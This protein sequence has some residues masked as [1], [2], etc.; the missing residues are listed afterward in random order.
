MSAAKRT[1]LI[2]KLQKV[3]KKHF[4]PHLPPADRP[5]LEH[6]LYACCLEDARPDAADQ[7]FALLQ[8]RYFDWNEVR[9]TSQTELA[10]VMGALK[11]P[12]AAANRLKRSLQAV[13]EE[14]YTFALEDIFKKLNLGEA[15]KRVERLEGVSPFVTSYLVQHAFGGHAIPLSQGGIEVLRIIGVISDAEAREKRAPG[16]ERAIPKTK[17]IE[18]ASLLQQLAAELAAAPFGPHIKSLLLEIDSDAKQRL[19]QRSSKSK[20]EAPSKSTGKS[21][22][23]TKSAEATAKS[24]TPTANKKPA[25][26]P[27]SKPSSPKPASKSSAPKSSTP[28]A[29]GAKSKSASKSAT[30]RLTKRKPR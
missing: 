18:F 5:I 17:G 11:S 15:V 1:A 19:P 20:K 25:K 12:A 13:F 21:K 4:K 23:K 6:L 22:S 7:V 29:A 28:K 26:K 27:A 16:L 10:E 14:Y 9:V 24:A 2:T 3:L 8:E 30:K